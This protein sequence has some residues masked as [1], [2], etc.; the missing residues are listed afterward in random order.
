MPG[1]QTSRRISSSSPLRD[2]FEGFFGG[3]DGVYEVAFFFENGGEGFADARL[4][5]RRSST[6]GLVIIVDSSGSDAEPGTVSSD[7]R[8]RATA[9]NF[10]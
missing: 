7:C 9:D 6:C 1:S 5:R 3:A 2:A 10:A 8:R 4:R